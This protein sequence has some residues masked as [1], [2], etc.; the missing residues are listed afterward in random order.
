MALGSNAGL[1]KNR[2]RGNDDGVETLLAVGLIAKALSD[3]EKEPEPN[4]C[5]PPI[6]KIVHV[7]VYKEKIY[8]VKEKDIDQKWEENKNVWTKSSNVN[9][10]K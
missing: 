7:P 8:V 6:T 10:N 9:W 1:I 4:H 3:I 2:N 5:P